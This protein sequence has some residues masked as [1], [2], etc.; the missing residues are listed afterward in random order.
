MVARL[1][2]LLAIAAVA[3]A[4]LTASRERDAGP[5]TARGSDTS[6]LGGYGSGPGGRAAARSGE[7]GLTD[8]QGRAIPLPPVPRNTVADMALVGRFTALALWE[9]QGRVM[10]TRYTRERGWEP[11]QPL[12]QIGGQ[13]SNARLASNRSGVA[14]A[15]WQH[16]VGRIDSLRYSRYEE[17]RGWNQPDVMP[18]AL[19]R[20][21]QP[22]KT[23]GGTVEEAAPRIE[24]D[25]RGNARGQ[26]LSGFD[27]TQL[28]ASTYVP[29]EG[30]ARPVDLPA[31][32]TASAAA[33]ASPR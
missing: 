19:P 32:T 14:M 26:W 6:V 8:T 27:E 33:P 2:A 22:G 20:P 11:P 24:V 16:T 4:V 31:D 25:A 28:Q 21:R 5:V 23:A 29:G 9:E 10:A 18:G 30:W 12:E 17:G 1:L 7:A 15:I 13:A 3:A